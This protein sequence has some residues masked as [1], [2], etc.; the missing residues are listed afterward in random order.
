MRNQRWLGCLVVMLCGCSAGKGVDTA[1]H[2]QT[3]DQWAAAWNSG[4]ADTLLELFTDDVVY[5]DVTFGAVNNGKEALKRFADAAFD[6][7]PGM[8]FEIKSRAISPDGK[9]GAFEWVWRGKQIKDFPGLA[10]TN[11][12]FEIRGMSAIEFKGTKIGRCSDYW[13]LATYMKQVGLAKPAEQV[14]EKPAD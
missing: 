14:A 12:P 5:E 6:A 2:E 7:F 9:T 8:S 11:T 3:V 10:A 1:L 4:D 13:D